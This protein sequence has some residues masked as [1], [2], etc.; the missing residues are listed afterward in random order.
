MP[1]GL[2]NCKDAMRRASLV[3]VD[4]DGT[5]LDSQHSVR[6][7]VA[8]AVHDFFEKSSSL[9]TVLAVATGRSRGSAL[10]KLAAGGI[11]WQQRCGVFLN[12]AVVHGEHGELIH[13]STIPEDL[14]QKIIEEFEKN[15]DVAVVLF[16]GDECHALESSDERLRVFLHETYGD[17]FPQLHR[18]KQNIL[19]EIAKERL[20]VHQVGIVTRDCRANEQSTLNHLRVLVEDATHCCSSEFSVVLPIPQFI[21]MM[22]RNTTKASGLRHLCESLGLTSD[23]VVAIGDAPNDIEMLRWAGTGVAMGN[24][25]ESVK[26]VA[27]AVVNPNDS[28]HLPGVAQLLRYLISCKEHRVSEK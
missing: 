12:G 18:S 23:S 10:Q 21:A 19:D 14:T 8:E 16:C 2:E 26:A 20:R 25:A 5:L 11:D 13:E 17:P 28:D 6:A 22:P 27:K 24:A 4:M 1:R 15:N 3:A 9:S 7:S